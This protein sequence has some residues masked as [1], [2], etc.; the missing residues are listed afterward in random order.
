MIGLSVRLFILERMLG[1]ETLGSSITAVCLALNLGKGIAGVE[2]CVNMLTEYSKAGYTQ[3]CIE[4]ASV[5]TALVVIE[6]CA[7][8]L[9]L[10]R[11]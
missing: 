1:G 4:H 10:Q 8:L 6:G 11:N 9:M 3:L 5:K 7:F 2:I